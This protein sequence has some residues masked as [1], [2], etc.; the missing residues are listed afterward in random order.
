MQK[1]LF[2]F[3][4]LISLSVQAR[5]NWNP[6]FMDHERFVHMSED[7]KREVVVKTMELMVEMESK[8]KKEVLTSGYSA[9]RFQKYVQ[10][11]QKLQNLIIGSAVAAPTDKTL[12][13]LAKEFSD[14]LKRLDGKGCLYGGY[15]SKMD[16]SGKFCRHPST[17]GTSTLEVAIKNAYI[18]KTVGK[19]CAGPDKISCNPVIFGYEPKST[20]PSCVPTSNPKIGAAHNVSYECMRTALKG[21]KKDVDARLKIIADSMSNGDSKKAFNDVHNFI[22]RT[23]VC[24][25]AK[26]D[27]QE[28][29]G[30][31]YVDYI[32]PHRTCLG[33]MNTLRVTKNDCAEPVIASEFAE[34]WTKFY[35]EK[36]FN[37]ETA[38]RNAPF[39]DEYKKLIY[40]PDVQAMCSPKPID[41]P[42]VKVDPPKKEWICNA[43]CE[44]QEVD[45]V[46]KIV[47]TIKEAGWNI[48]TPPATEAVLTPAKELTSTFNIENNKVTEYSVELADKTKQVC[49]TVM[50][51]APA[52]PKSCTITVV[53]DEAVPGSAKATVSFQGPEELAVSEIRWKGAKEETGPGELLSVSVTQTD[54]EQDISVEFFTKDA[55]GAIAPAP[56]PCTGKVPVK[57]AAAEEEYA[58]TATA[59]PLKTP[60]DP[61][62]KVTAKLTLKGEPAELPV[63]HHY[64][65]SRK[66]AGAAK[67]KAPEV[68]K[69]EETTTG[70]GDFDA[71]GKPIVVEKPK[72]VKVE[73]EVKTGNPIDEP[74]VEAGY[75]ACAVLIEDATGKVKTKTPGCAPIPELKAPAPPYVAPVNNNQNAAP[76][77]FFLPVN[78]TI[79]MGVK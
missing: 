25:D 73:G 38:A 42:P 43:T 19:S 53:P 32:R 36:V 74:R 60:Q 8:Y 72:E 3:L 10:V 2:L 9:E 28:V 29:M 76:P 30:T 18:N 61:T 50:A 13:T 21:E 69:D 16:A 52:V 46:K 14:L 64:S 22:F 35:G 33:M 57:T 77:T 23:C 5:A 41:P 7:Q 12:P 59:D 45:K 20:L 44:E 56:A 11:I 31:Y 54:V 75:E 40:L 49:K 65:W 67:V 39:D 48:T 71:D 70:T 6:Y 55:K 79:Q 51:E 1:F 62:V 78:N 63:G 27:K 17:M 58:I 66:G 37:S 47:C 24:N 34:E 15:V 68:K 4:A 26:I